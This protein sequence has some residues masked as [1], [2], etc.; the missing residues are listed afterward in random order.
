MKQWFALYTQ[1]RREKALDKELAKRG[2]EAYLPL[3]STLRQWKDRKKRVDM[4]LI[5]SYLFVKTEIQDFYNVLQLSGAVKFVYFEGKPV[6]VPQHQID[7][8]RLLLDKE[9]EFEMR[10]ADVHVGDR[11]RIREGRFAGLTGIVKNEKGKTR[12]CVVVDVLRLDLTIEIDKE[13]VQLVD[14]IKY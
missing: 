11:V 10:L 4:P 2:I 13:E 7:S 9:I 6:P 8:M 1:P 5:P 12:F 14:I 3:K